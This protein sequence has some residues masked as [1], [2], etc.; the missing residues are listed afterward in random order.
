LANQKYDRLPQLYDDTIPLTSTFALNI[1]L[2]NGQL[3]SRQPVFD[4]QIR[5]A[6]KMPAVVRDQRNT[7]C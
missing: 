7:L 1:H 4:S 2:E 6:L 5:Y 3:C